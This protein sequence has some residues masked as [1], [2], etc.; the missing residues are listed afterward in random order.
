MSEQSSIGAIFDCDGT[1]V[2]S[3][4]VWRELEAD[5]A[6]RVNVSLSRD[7]KDAIMAMTIPEVGEYFHNTYGLGDSAADVV[8]M[9]NDFMMDFYTTKATLKPGAAE[10]VA[11]LYERG[12]PMCVASSTPTKLLVACM[13]HLGLAPYFQAIVSVD[14]VGMSKRDARVYDYCRKIM[15]T[16]K[17]GTWGFEDAI[18]AIHTLKEARYPTF[19]IFD[20]DLSGTIQE[21]QDTADRTALSFTEVNPDAFLMLAEAYLQEARDRFPYQE[22]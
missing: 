3:M 13:E 9:I 5:L 22:D 6:A 21:L 12:V 19:A 10:F 7:E 11:G 17:A 8:Q 2:D 14:D 1:L 4:D 16:E 20:C 15:G 18:Y